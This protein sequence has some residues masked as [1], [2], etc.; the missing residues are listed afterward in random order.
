MVSRWP[1]NSGQ[2]GYDILEVSV[3]EPVDHILRPQLPWRRGGG[4]TECGY[5]SEKVPTLTREAYFQRVKE[6]GRQRAAMLTCMTC[7]DAATRWSTWDD[8]PRQ[9]MQR[10]L[11]WEGGYRRRDRGNRTHD[12]LLAISSLIDAHRDEFDAHVR[13][14]EQRRDWNEKKAAHAELRKNVP[15][16]RSL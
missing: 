5:S 10:E 12:E 14:T 7:S 11:E 4:V 16:D 3:K 13:E 9:A 2:I 1:V 8:D 6:F 15:K